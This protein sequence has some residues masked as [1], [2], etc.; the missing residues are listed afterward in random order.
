MPDETP[1]AP[2]SAYDQLTPKQKRFVD[3]YVDT[4]SVREALRQAGYGDTNGTT[5]RLRHAAAIE[6]RLV[7][8]AMPKAEVAGRLTRHARADMAD[9]VRVSPVERTYWVRADLH[10]E[11]G[12]LAV[13]RG[14]SADSLDEL[15]LAGHYG[16]DAVAQTQDG[17][18]L[19]RVTQISSEVDIDWA[20]VEQAGQLGQI[21]RLKKNKDGSIEFELHDSVRAL[22]S[23]GRAHGMFT[24]KLEH[25]GPGGEPIKLYASVEL[26]RV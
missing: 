18:L 2:K 11:T 5:M 3:V 21:K 14:T 25:S 7:L 20:G 4:L 17:Q 9:F 1:T 13:K 12:D 22:E 24:D 19:V 8:V 26:D 10:P 16:A 15:D 23:L 6:E